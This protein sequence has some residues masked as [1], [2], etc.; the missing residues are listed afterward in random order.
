MRLRRPRGTCVLMPWS[1]RTLTVLILG[2]VAT[3]PVPSL[4]AA[5]FEI[6]SSPNT[7]QVPLGE[8]CTDGSPGVRCS[9]GDPCSNATCA[10]TPGAICGSF[11][12]QDQVLYRGQLIGKLCQPNFFKP[13]S[14][15]YITDCSNGQAGIEGGAA[16]DAAGVVSPATPADGSTPAPAA[17]STSAVKGP[18][19]LP[20]LAPKP[21]N[22]ETPV[23]SPAAE[24]I[25]TKPFFLQTL[26]PNPAKGASMLAPAAGAGTGG[27]S[28]AQAPALTPSSNLGRSGSIEGTSPATQQ[29][30]PIAAGTAAGAGRA[31]SA[32]ITTAPT[33][34]LS[35]RTVVNVD[36]VQAA[37]FAV[38]L[39]TL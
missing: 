26:A 38:L 12:C 13:G 25:P 17:E 36:F 6:G 21:A 37:V 39:F 33:P 35:Q 18:S 24:L 22:S 19:P 20:V 8:P 31:A 29:P 4:S 2:I 5:L 10:S 3:W 16:S 23:P 34:Q 9:G 30:T 32:G 15:D 14:C 11:F 28:P 7:C 1:C 27:T